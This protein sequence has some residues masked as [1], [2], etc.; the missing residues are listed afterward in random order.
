MRRGF[1]RRVACLA[2][3]ADADAGPCRR[4]D[5]CKERSVLDE[6]PGAYRDIDGMMAN[7]AELVDVVHTLRQVVCVKG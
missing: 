2:R 4:P 3:P 6:A 1:D 5:W 7:Q